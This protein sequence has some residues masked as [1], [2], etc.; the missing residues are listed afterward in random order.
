[1]KLSPRFTML[2]LIAAGTVITII[3]NHRAI[4]NLRIANQNLVAEGEEAK[5]LARENQ[6][7][8]RL[9]PLSM[10]AEKLH[11]ANHD[12]P[13]L[14]NEVRVLREKA[15]ALKTLRA[16]NERLRMLKKNSSTAQT[17]TALPPDF[18]PKPVLR[19]AGL[20]SPEA[21]VQTAF[22]AMCHGDL[23]RWS[24]CLLDGAER[25]QED[26]DWQRKNLAEE[27]KSFFG[28][29][30]VHKQIISPTEVELGLQSSI[31]GIVLP[32]KLK[33][34]DKQWKWDQK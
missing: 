7:I 18:L 1:M 34:V 6:E 2:F 30:I 19:D 15:S 12:L 22:W 20:G 3:F 25:L 27:M 10:E 17:P 5:R 33:L 9:G 24:Q 32:A 23:N 29:R 28:F 8:D 21:T 26:Q 14:R 31:E 4:S 16:E 13:R 11:E